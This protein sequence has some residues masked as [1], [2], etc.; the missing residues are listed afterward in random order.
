MN[1]FSNPNHC[2]NSSFTFN[3][4][5]ALSI[6]L[7]FPETPFFGDAIATRFIFTTKEGKFLYLSVTVIQLLSV[8]SSVVFSI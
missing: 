8:D 3:A 6:D 5:T 2:P 1:G 4:Y 7:T